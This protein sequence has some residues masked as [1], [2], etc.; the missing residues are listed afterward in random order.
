MQKPT[1]HIPRGWNRQAHAAWHRGERQ[2][3]IDLVLEDCNAAKENKPV[4]KVLQLAYYIFLCNDPA[5][6]ANFLE[7]ARRRHPRHIELLQ[8]LA[9]C[10]YRSGQYAQALERIEEVLA[11]RPDDVAALDGKCSALANLG[12]RP[13][14]AVAGTRVLQLKDLASDP[15]PAG[16]KLPASTPQAWAAM[17]GKRSVIAFSLWGSHPRY[18]RGAL[19][20]ALAAPEIYPGWT[21]VFFVD[22]TAPART[23]ERLAAL[24][25]EIVRER[26][27]QTTREKL[28]WRFRVANDPAVGRFLVR[29]VD[30]VIGERERA[31][32]AEW[33]ASDCWFHV[34]RDWWTHTDLMLAGMWGGVAGVLP[35]LARMVAD[36][37]PKTA[38]TPNVDQ[39]FLRDRV[40]ACVRTSCLVHDRCFSP[41]GARP[42]PQ[43]D[44]E[45]S[46]HVGQ[47][48]HA[49]RRPQQDERLA[50]RFPES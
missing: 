49:A 38:E 7:Q 43:P 44:P 2:A 37:N 45:G 12:R 31:A 15:P 25:A 10:L 13:E 30:S 14:A 8:N 41:P 1:E 19:D 9:V 34:M 40:W 46:F 21:P 18:L 50:R 27:G 3:A 28:T 29:D 4:T 16:W 32:V 39:W 42:W 6:A 35:D 11:L 33:I 47:N 20:N 22:D 17:P 5:A 26:P 23:L 24:G 36:Y 48:E